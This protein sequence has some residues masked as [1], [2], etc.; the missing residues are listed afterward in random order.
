MTHIFADPKGSSFINYDPCNAC[1]CAHVDIAE[2]AQAYFSIDY[3]DW[4]SIKKLIFYNTALDFSIT[5]RKRVYETSEENKEKVIL[6]N[7]DAYASTGYYEFTVPKEFEVTQFISE[8]SNLISVEI[9]EQEKDFNVKISVNQ[10]FHGTDYIILKPTDE[11]SGDFRMVVV[12]NKN[13]LPESQ[14]YPPVVIDQGKISSDGYA[15]IAVIAEATPLAILGEEVQFDVKIK[16]YDC[17]QREFFHKMCLSFR[18][19]R[20]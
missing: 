14:M 18:I 9:T 20:C 17:A 8:N 2:G 11:V 4:V 5:P 19:G 15:S 1:C 13:S 12:T 16:G 7:K 3:A 6:V 10:E